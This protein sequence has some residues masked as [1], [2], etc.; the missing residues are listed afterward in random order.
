[1]FP[2]LE[3]SFLKKQALLHFQDVIRHTARTVAEVIDLLEAHFL[4]HRARRVSDEIWVSLS[5]EFVKKKRGAEKAT[6]THEHILADL[7][8][9]I[10][11]LA[12]SRTGPG[13]DTI[14]MA[15]AI[16]AVRDIGV[17][18]T[19]CQDPPTNVIDLN[20]TLLSCT[21]ETDR[22]DMT[23]GISGIS[24]TLQRR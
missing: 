8:E 2:L 11:D 5:Y 1:M 14:I 22:Q 23:A 9:Q 4:G 19:V 3:T 24:H 20:S 13:S 7:L 10:A 6:I 17:Y 18:S 21:L 16:A 15:K 12:D